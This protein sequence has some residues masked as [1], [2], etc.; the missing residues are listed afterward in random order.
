M[1]SVTKK[2]TDLLR[3]GFGYANYLAYCTFVLLN[4]DVINP[5]AI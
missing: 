3:I 5:S 1:K 4:S 2:K